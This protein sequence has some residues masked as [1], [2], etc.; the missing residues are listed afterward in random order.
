LQLETGSTG[1]PVS[2]GDLRYV[3]IPAAA[4]V[5]KRVSQSAVAAA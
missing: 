5:I 2:D 4:D 1:K 3:L